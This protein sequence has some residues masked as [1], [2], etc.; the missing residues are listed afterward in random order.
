LPGGATKLAHAPGPRYHALDSLRA[1]AM[2]L[3]LWLHASIPYTPFGPKF[4]A[5]HEDTNSEPLLFSLMFIHSFRMQLFFMMAGFFAHLLVSR[6]GTRR[7]IRNRSLRV[8]APFAIAMVTIGPALLVLWI[9]GE[10]VQPPNTERPQPSGFFIPTF[11]LW[12]L[13][14][15]LFMYA[16]MLLL[17][18]LARFL[19]I[20]RL[21][22][23]SAWLIRAPLLPIVLAVP[24]AGLLWLIPGW[25]SGPLKGGIVPEPGPL[26]YY[27]FFFAFGWV[28]FSRR[29]LLDTLA[30]WWIPQ[31]AIALVV[32]TPVFLYAHG[33]LDNLDGAPVPLQLD[34]IGHAS[35]ALL[36]CLLTIA[37]TGMFLR[38]F[39]R[40]SR[41]GRYISDASY[42]L[43]LVHLPIQIV[44]SMLLLALPVDG[45]FKFLLVLLVTTPL[46]LLVYHYAVRY[47]PIGWMLNGKRHHPTH[48]A[49]LE[50]STAT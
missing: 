17:S 20:A 46:M 47:T 28:L 25:E 35:A 22:P 10:I 16:G 34:L 6:R 5:V 48:E 15:L 11:H 21:A 31:L 27:S 44:A 30:R 1:I 32:V 49:V 2:L 50:C 8:L 33:R 18:P 38:C 40:P 19:G 39:N 23:L 42:W 13:E 45:H 26:A 4:W 43:Y 24:A 14:Y 36:T 9:L 7:F 3:G 41:W 29:D 12:F 37:F